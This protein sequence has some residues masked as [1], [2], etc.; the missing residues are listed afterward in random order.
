VRRSGIHPI[1]NLGVLTGAHR[2]DEPRLR[3]EPVFDV[4]D[5]LRQ[6]GTVI[7]DNGPWPS[8]VDII[9]SSETA[10]L[11]VDATPSGIVRAATLLREWAGPRP[12]LVL[13]RTPARKPGTVEA[14]LQTWTGLEPSAVIS[15]LPEVR[16]AAAGGNR[17]PRRLLKHLIGVLP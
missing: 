9:K 1:G 4:V 10:I 14:A 3:P 12:R 8:G 13:N 15:Y 6:D 5:A 17:P 7:V 11:V 2:S 16:R